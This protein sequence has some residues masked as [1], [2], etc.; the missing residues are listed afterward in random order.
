MWAF[1]LTLTLSTSWMGALMG[2]IVCKYGGD[3]AISMVE[4]AICAKKFTDRRTQPDGRRTPRDCIRAKNRLAHF[5]LRQFYVSYVSKILHLLSPHGFFQAQ[6]P[7]EP[8]FRWS[9]VPDP[10]GRAYDAPWRVR[11]V[12]WRRG[13]PPHSL[14]RALTSTPS[15]S[16]S[17]L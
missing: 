1:R 17:R 16:R 10:T 11:V 6:N 9:S 15:A 7:P 4:E 5:K 8:V 13:T 14:P 12:G 3:P 2:T